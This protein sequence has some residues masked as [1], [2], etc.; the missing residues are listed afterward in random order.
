MVKFVELKKLTAI[1]KLITLGLLLFQWT[2]WAQADALAKYTET[3]IL[4]DGEIDQQ[5]STLAPSS[6]FWE[7]FPSD[8]LQAKQQT[9]VKF[10]YDKQNLY[11]LIIAE[12]DDNQYITSTL[13]RDFSFR[14][15]DS[16]TLVLDTFNDGTNAFMFGT[17]PEGVKRE[18]LIA[19]GGNNFR[20][21]NITWDVKWE[22]EVK[23]F[24]GGYIS[25]M[26]IPLASL[27]YPD[28]IE[29]WRVNVY[30]SELAENSISTWANVPRNQIIAGLAFMKTLQFEKKLPQA[31]TPVALIPFISGITAKDFEA[32]DNSS[33]FS[34]GGDAKLS[35]GDGMILDLTLQP[36]FSQVEVDDQIINLTRFEVRLPEKRQFF[37]QNSDLFDNFGDN[38]ESQPFFSRRIG[39]AKDLDG[40]TIQNKIIAGARLSGKINPKLRLG[41][42]NMQT[43][44]DAPNGIAANNNTVFT[45]QQQMFSRSNL[46]FFFINRQQTGDDI[47]SSDQTSF[48][49]V[50][51]MDYNLASKN[52]QWTGRTYWHQSFVPDQEDE[53]Y[54]AGFR[55]EHNSRKHSAVY[56]T[57]RIGGGFQSDLG[58]IRRTD[59][60]KQ[61]FRYGHRFWID[62]KNIRSI[63][64][65]QSVFY[66][67][68][69]ATD[70]LVT[71]RSISTRSEISFNDQSELRLDY[72]RRYTYL[73]DVF[74]PLGKDDAV[75]LP[76]ETGYYYNGFE[77]NYRSN[78]SKPINYNVQ[79][80]FGDFYNG[81]RLS[82]RSQVSVRVQ[83]RFS[84]SLRVNYDKITFPAP[85]TSGEL[86]LIGP[87]LDYTFSKSV[88]WNTFIQYSSQSENFSINSRLQW[89]FAP[90]SDF[91]LV[92]NDNY[93]AETTLAPKVR[94]LTFKLT[95]WLSI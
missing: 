51:G 36:D 34:F 67:D 80:S 95:Y 83:P 56:N 49:R 41:F 50:V 78:F 73:T 31:K 63:E 59:I 24:D 6:P 64:L 21:F 54:S 61:F 25:E 15:G 81:Q 85:Y 91:Y 26:K 22:T 84:G 7:Y 30:R 3:P 14:T 23:K 32:N 44:E 93:F 92:Y 5:W 40:N 9:Q 94:S 8:T 33:D 71:D 35:I 57:N 46:G 62:G 86:W 60:L 88:F 19:N 43:A 68:K 90:L 76:A 77:L 11:V 53:S 55:L 48:N 74:N 2:C 39:V 38:R 20:D 42:L 12:D 18:A 58:F 87:K 45:L 72:S 1:K 82:I 28:N 65:S 4:I 70:G 16:V 47:E 29:Q 52:N 79:A 75:G 10:M 37:I 17:N 89:R 27:R 13:R 66:V 69:P